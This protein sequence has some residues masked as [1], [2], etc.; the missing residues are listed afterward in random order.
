MIEGV[1]GIREGKLG[2]ADQRAVSDL[3]KFF[4]GPFRAYQHV[5]AV[6]PAS[7]FLGQKAQ[8]GAPTAPDDDGDD[9]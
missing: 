5:P 4:V 8:K 3:S 6:E 9:E 7:F 2:V 1:F